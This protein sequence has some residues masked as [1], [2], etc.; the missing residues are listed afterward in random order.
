MKSRWPIR[1]MCRVL[2]VSESGYYG[3]RRSDKVS[4]R[5]RLPDQRIVVHIRAIH[6]EVNAE[7]G[8]PRMYQAL[9]RRGL[10]VGKERVRVLMQA[11]GIRGKA[12]RRYV[13]T[14]DSKHILPVAPNRVQRHFTPDAPNQIWCSDITYLPTAQGWLY[15]AAV[16]D[17]FNRQ[18][19][20]W[21]LKP[22]M[23]TSLVKEA[24]TMAYH[25]RRPGPGLIFH[26]DRGSQYCSDEFQATLRTWQMRASMSRK[27]DCWD[28]APIESFWARLKQA[29]L[30]GRKF[31]SHRHTVAVV[32]DWIA[33]YNHRRLHSA[34]G[35]MSP[36]E[37]EKY[38]H[39]RQLKIAA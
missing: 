25:R 21:S 16:M 8:W 29:C 1:A 39:A 2:S 10:R 34:L 19:V 35:Y 30:E 18:V 22:H 33:F 11:H 9:R 28:N 17:L 27:G 3:W 36:M 26:S 24:L 15:L 12:K 13:A 14:T 23:Q 37:Y 31:P 6:R 4:V 32:M 38:W 5:T 20:G 7:Y